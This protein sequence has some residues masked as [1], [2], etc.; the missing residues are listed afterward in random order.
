MKENNS[1]TRKVHTVNTGLSN[2]FHVISSLTF[3]A[4]PSG[5]S[6]L[7]FPMNPPSHFS[8]VGS[9]CDSLH[10]KEPAEVVGLT[11]PVVV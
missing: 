3:W 10:V 7:L 5:Y 4:G 9:G 2:P 8:S 6:E 11:C 1:N